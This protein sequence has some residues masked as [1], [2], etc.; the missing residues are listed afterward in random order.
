MSGGLFS[1]VLLSSPA[2]SPQCHG[3]SRD[4]E[5]STHLA[6]DVVVGRPTRRCAACGPDPPGSSEIAVC[7]EGEIND[8]LLS[9]FMP[10]HFPNLYLL[11]AD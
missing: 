1:F 7:P 5:R 3:E 8:S 2:H 6:C 4:S 10:P 9:R 11:R